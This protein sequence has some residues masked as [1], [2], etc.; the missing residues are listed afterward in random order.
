MSCI[1]LRLGTRQW[2]LGRQPGPGPGTRRLIQ[3][4]RRRPAG[5]EFKFGSS[6][7]RAAQPNLWH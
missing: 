3:Q 5:P 7:Y 4:A 2:Q 1:G 6:R